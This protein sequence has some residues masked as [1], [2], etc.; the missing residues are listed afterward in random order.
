MSALNPASQLSLDESGLFRFA[1]VSGGAW[2]SEGPFL[3]LH[4]YDRQHPRAQAV[5]APSGGGHAYGTAG[6]PS[7]GAQGKLG[8]SRESRDSISVCAEFSNIDISVAIEIRVLEGGEGFSVRIDDEGVVEGNPGLYRILGL[9]VL[10]GFGAA[11]TG[12]AG[13]LTLPN[14]SGCQTFLT[15]RIP[16]RFGRRST[17]A[18]TSGSMS[19]IWASLALPAIMARS[20]ASLRRETTTPS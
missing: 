20:A 2:T 8:V 4:Y 6:T 16:A 17:A 7:L 18:M 5:A 19:A 15:R 1:P 9:E 10:P 3:I 12:E 11:R 13:Y 14:W